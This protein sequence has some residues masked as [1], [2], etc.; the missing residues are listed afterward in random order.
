M[1]NWLKRLGFA[2][3]FIHSANAALAQDLTIATV[4]RTP[5]SQVEN[6]EDT[7]FSVELWG[8]IAAELNR[9]YT[10]QRLDSFQEML[11]AVENG[12]AD[13]AVANISIT[14]ER[15]ARFDFSQPIFSSGLRIMIRAG[16]GSG[17]SVLSAI[18]NRDFLIASLAAFALLFGGGLLMWRLESNKG[19]PYFQGTAR[20]KAFPSFW[21]ALNLVVNGGFEERVPHTILGRVFATILVVSSLFIVSLF[22]ANITAAMTVSAIQSS[23]QSVNDLYDKRVGTT[24]GSTADTFLERREVGHQG[25]DSLDAL[26]EAFESHEIDAVVFDA[27]ILSYYVNTIG[28]GKGELVGPVFLRENYGFAL[29]PESPLREPINRMLL[30][31]REDGTYDAL[32][33][34]WFGTDAVR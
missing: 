26:I 1:N 3:L 28:A 34:E 31:F 8:L 21:W 27:P 32:Y 9:S 29:A 6:G 10:I 13:I 7:G 17:S 23:V 11:S 4:T 25:F 19:Q 12:T 20:E 14:A 30:R 2:L 33:V 22:V 15:E 16:Q 18:W 5:F 24:T